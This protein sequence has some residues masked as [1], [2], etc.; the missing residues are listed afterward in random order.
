MK[1]PNPFVVQ[2][3]GRHDRRPTVHLGWYLAWWDVDYGDG[4]GLIHTLP[5]PFS[6]MVLRY[7][8]AAD[9]DAVFRRPSRVRP[10]GADGAPHR[11]LVLYRWA[12]VDL[13]KLRAQQ[14]DAATR[15][16]QAAGLL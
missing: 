8:A 1:E 15:H 13:R 2:I 16:A 12:T 5:D 11:P 7:R 4:I 10:I 9:A 14:L 6:P 3:V